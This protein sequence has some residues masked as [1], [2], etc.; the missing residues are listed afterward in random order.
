MIEVSHMAQEP[1]NVVI[2]IAEVLVQKHK[3]SLGSGLSSA[4]K[5][6]VKYCKG[7]FA[8]STA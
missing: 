4:D 3:R 8:N 1:G 5:S 7:S 2:D 6:L